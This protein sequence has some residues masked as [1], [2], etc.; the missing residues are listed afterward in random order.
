MTTQKFD[1][2]LPEPKSHRRFPFLAAATF[3][4]VLAC[5][6]LLV[7]RSRERP[8]A[9]SAVRPETR[10]RLSPEDLKRLAQDL[11]RRTLYRQAAEAWREYLKA[12]WPELEP[13]QIHR[14]LYLQAKNL[15]DAGAYAEA[16][17]C[18]TEAEQYPAE[19]KEK[20]RATRL[21]LECLSALGKEEVRTYVLR[22]KTVPG[23]REKGTAVARIGGEPVT[24][25]DLRGE[26]E[27]RNL[28][29]MQAAGSLEP[30]E[31][32]RRKARRA[33][34]EKLN[35]PKFRKEFLKQYLTREV[36]YREAL[37]RR[38]QEGEAFKKAL[39]AYRK[40]LLARLLLQQEAEAAC[41][42]ITETDLKNHYEAHRDRFV[43]PEGV[44]FA[45]RA[46]RTEEEARKALAG[47]D[48]AEGFTEAPQPAVRGAP[49]P[50][51]G[52]SPE[53][54]ALLFALN[55]GE[56]GGRPISIGGRWY[57]FKC[58]G[59]RPRR[60]KTFEEAKKEV[61]AD[62]ARAKRNEAARSIGELLS[63]KYEVE[64]LLQET[65]GTASGTEKGSAAGEAGASTSGGKAPEK[66]AET[67][68]QSKGVSKK[69]GSKK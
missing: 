20:R 18:L 12:A 32:L 57:L 61:W 44:F 17:R 24:L 62:L 34:E 30:V 9:P 69:K 22:A 26:L 46:F 53:A 47:G 50:G 68:G 23:A 2:S 39:A 59:K 60:Q 48:K 4:G 21:L 42:S 65:S 1:F 27:E 5:L 29:L 64:I 15:C 13:T 31:V 38:I 54:V 7:F 35:D 28:T 11:E 25:E 55:E 19:R 58:I 16:A 45:Y 41:R 3:L 6:A 10:V 37:E 52:E 8:N 56:V 40:E 36:L 67:R 33:A 63:A 51:I 66:G 14:V 43:E 49:L